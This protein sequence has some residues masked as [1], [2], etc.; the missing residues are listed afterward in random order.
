MDILPLPHDPTFTTPETPYLSSEEWD[1]G[2]FEKY[3][4]RKYQHLG[5]RDAPQLP[6]DSA[7]MKLTLQRVF[8]SIPAA[9]LQSFLQ[10][11]LYFG[12]I[13]EFLG[14][15]ETT[16]GQR[17][18]PLE[19]AREE[20]AAL[21][22]DMLQETESGNRLLSGLTVLSKSDLFKERVRLS[23][24]IPA[25]LLYLHGCLSRAMLMINNSY[26]QLDFCIRYSIAGL[27]EMFMTSLYSSSHLFTP[28]ITLPLAGFNWFR[29]YLIEGGEVE[30]QMLSFGWCPSEIQKIRNLFQ[31]VSSL[32]YVSRLRP[33]TETSAH[34]TCTS[35]SCRA[36]QI[37]ITKYKPRH[38]AEDCQCKDVQVDES[39]LSDILRTT[40]S[41]PVLT[42]DTSADGTVSVQ[43][44]TYEPGMQYV[45][46]SHVWADGLGNPKSNALPSCQVSKVANSI[47]QL[48]QDLNGENSEPPKYRVWVDTIC[49]PVELEGKAI[50]LD[51]I[52]SVYENSTHVLVL[53]SSLTCLD[54]RTCEKAELLLKTFSCSPWMRRLWT[55]QGTVKT[56][57]SSSS[58]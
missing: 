22:R 34:I 3:L 13:A 49:C 35:Y 23:S 5:L 36:F 32:H 15:N 40:E 11:W 58:Y 51:R 57:T 44:E 16:D 37:D 24:D 17:Y 19:Q 27:A 14:L 54:T 39:A 6:T 7:L 50:A 42:I 20:I 10:T 12:L 47:A 33:R 9:K 53:D 28:K 41:F 21:H 31:G 45:A 52:T 4:D 30:K 43:M 46:L 18:V 26:N 56:F 48:S 38:V 29:E 55:L 1:L 2:P 25:R 8:D